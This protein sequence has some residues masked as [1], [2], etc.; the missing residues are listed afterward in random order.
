VNIVLKKVVSHCQ[1]WLH[2]VHDRIHKL[3]DT[4]QINE[5]HTKSGI[6]RENSATIED[7]R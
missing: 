4:A 1:N 6:F 3:G 5:N 2:F 7:I